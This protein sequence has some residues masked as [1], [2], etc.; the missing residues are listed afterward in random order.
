[1]ENDVLSVCGQGSQLKQVFINILD[2]AKEAI[3][4]EGTI[5]VSISKKDT[6]CK[7]AIEDNGIGIPADR[8]KYL[9]EPFF[10]NKEKGIG[11]GLTISNKIIHDHKGK[12]EIESEEQ[13]GTIVT[14]CLPLA[15]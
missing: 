1:M 12:I 3:K 6:C 13:K 8:M 9:G 10:T 7:I 2:N 14:I 4:D 15:E 5:K 11:L